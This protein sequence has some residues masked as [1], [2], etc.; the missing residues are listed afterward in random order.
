MVFRSAVIIYEWSLPILL[1]AFFLDAKGVNAIRPS[2]FELYASF[3]RSSI[4]N[5]L[6]GRFLCPTVKHDEWDL[7]RGSGTAAG[8][9]RGN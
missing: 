5:P 3:P 7:V 8:L 4:F 6:T 1:D 2:L 9:Y